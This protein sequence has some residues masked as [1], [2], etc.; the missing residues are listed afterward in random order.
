MI[1][2]DDGSTDNTAELIKSYKRRF[3]EAGIELIYEYQKNQG[4]GAAMNAGLKLF[5]G[6]FLCWADP[7]DFL[8]EASIGHKYL[9]NYIL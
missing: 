5:T 4:V 6:D 8:N 7:D 3:L 9:D 2:I 1:C